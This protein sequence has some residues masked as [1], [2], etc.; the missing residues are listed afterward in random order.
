MSDPAELSAENVHLGSW[1]LII[2]N[3]QT[4]SLLCPCPP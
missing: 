1:Y 2:S 4:Y 3:F